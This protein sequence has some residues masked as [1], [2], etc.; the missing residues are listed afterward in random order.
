MYGVNVMPECTIHSWVHRFDD[1]KWENI[2]NNEKRGGTW[3]TKRHF[4]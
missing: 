1:E 3:W 4:D 2:H